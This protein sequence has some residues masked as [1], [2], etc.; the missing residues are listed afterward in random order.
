M[1]IHTDKKAYVVFSLW[2]R[3]FHWTMVLSVTALFWTGLYIGDPGFA[4]ITGNPEPTFAIDGWFSMETMRRIHFTAGVILTFSFIFRFAGALW[5]RGDRLLPKF[6][7]KRYWYGLKE[8]TLHYLMIP[9]K[10][11]HHWLR[12]SL[13]RT[14]YMMVYI[15]FFFE[16]LTGFAM[17]SMIEPNGVSRNVIFTSGYII[18]WGIQSPCYPSLHCVG[19]LVL[20]YCSRVY[21]I[22]RRCYGGIG[23]SI[24]YG[25]RYEILRS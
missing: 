7:Q 18:W 24:G 16:I 3:I 25:F 14:A 12:N 23:R 5:N 11:E 9:Q 13:A 17:Y 2:L 21:G 1:L 20:Y 10:H 6:R 15:M 19:I 4:A 22:P 8:T